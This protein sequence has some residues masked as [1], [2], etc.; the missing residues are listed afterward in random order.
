LGVLKTSGDLGWT[1]NE[2]PRGGLVIGG[3]GSAREWSREEGEISILR[4]ITTG[5]KKKRNEM[6]RRTFLSVWGMGR[7]T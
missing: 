5:S 6:N 2:T 1:T 4:F 3:G 7:R